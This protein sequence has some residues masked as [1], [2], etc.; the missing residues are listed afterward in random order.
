MAK[1]VEIIRDVQIP[2]AALVH[3]PKVK[4][5]FR[6]VIKCLDCEFYGGLTERLIGPGLPFN[7][8]Y[9]VICIHPMSR[10]I[11]MESEE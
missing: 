9:Q 7:A 4:F 10:S 8:R 1:V 11:Q 2:P 3:C 5:N 6:R